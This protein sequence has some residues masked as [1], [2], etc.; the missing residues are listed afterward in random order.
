V[1]PDPVAVID[2]WFREL[3]P[4]HWFSGAKRLDEAMRRRFADWVD[5]ALQGDLD[6][7]SATPRGRLALILLLDQFTRNIHR[8]TPGAFAGD[9]KAEAL[10]VEGVAVGMDKPLNLAERH[11]FYMPLMHAE[12]L[13]LQQLA[14]KKFNEILGEAKS[15]LNIRKAA[16]R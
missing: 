5:T 6:A 4:R 7:W 11:F 10:V 2:F 8:G 9:A 13:A 1:K 14:A 16:D 12:D 15:M 3:E